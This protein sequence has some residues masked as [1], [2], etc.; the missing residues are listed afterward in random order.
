MSSR[1]LPARRLTLGLA[2]AASVLA[3]TITTP[4]RAQPDTR[5]AQGTSGT[6]H[7]L[8][9]VRHASL[10]WGVN[11]IYQ[12]GNPANANCN[13]FSAGTQK[14][15]RAARGNVRVVH[16][17]PDG[18][19]QGVS[20]ATKCVPG[21]PGTRLNQRVLFTN[22]TGKADGTTGSATIHWRGSFTANAYGG[23]VTWYL[24]NPT[25]K[26]ARD[27]SGTLTATGGGMGADRDAPERQAEVPPRRV[28]VATFDRVRLDRTAGRGGGAQI[29][30]RFSGVDYFPL[31]DGVRSTTSAIP[32]AVKKAEPDWGSWP[33]SFVDLQYETG[34]SSYW[35]TSGLSADPDKPPY[36]L[37]VRFDSAPEIRDVPVIRANPSTTATAP[38]IEGRDLV[39]KAEAQHATGF[40]WERAASASGPWSPVDGASGESLTIRSV[41]SSWNG[42]YVRLAATNAEGRAVSAA[43]RLTTAPYAAPTFAEQPRDLAAIQG[44]DATVAFKLTGN[45]AIDPKA[46]AL[47]RSSDGGATWKPWTEARYGGGAGQFTL[48]AI[49]LTAD[50]TMARVRAANTEGTTVTSA[51]FAVRVFPATGKPQL[52]VIPDR[53]VDPTVAT[54]LTVL[55]AGF[56]VPDWASPTLTY[57]LD[58]GLFDAEVWQPG[59][60]GTRDWIATSPQSSGGQLYHDAL[61]ASGGAFTVSL[62]VPAGRLVPGHDYGIGAFLRLTDTVTWR[63]TF[64][65]RSLDAWTPLSASR[66]VVG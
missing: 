5:A 56:N 42:T 52:A 12:G 13:Y 21:G 51:P 57:S 1:P 55:G 16:R 64:E 50:G 15:F 45:P 20:D 53:P 40:Q 36:D 37:S 39:I 22:G 63:D 44:T 28:T 62:T 26:I 14:E 9:R 38:Y 2:A 32:D 60:Q 25:L 34:L 61:R 49:P 54:R 48:P 41:D 6:A 29:S 17:M 8:H 11:A 30:P 4:A 43:L 24:K 65:N 19:A 47:E 66:E 59:R 33:R 3:L 7:T 10:E 46:V 58:L 23:L 31:V 18:T 27:G 35:H